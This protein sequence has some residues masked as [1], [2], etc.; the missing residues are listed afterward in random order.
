VPV[1]GLTLAERLILKAQRGLHCFPG[2]LA[3]KARD[4]LARQAEQVLN[5][6][7]LRAR[8]SL[9]P[10]SVYRRS[11]TP[12]R[13]PFLRFT[14]FIQL[15]GQ[16]LQVA[17]GKVVLKL[18][19]DGSSIDGA[20]V[21]LDEAILVTIT[22]EEAWLAGLDVYQSNGGMPH[23]DSED[24]SLV[25]S[26]LVQLID[27]ENPRDLNG[28][29]TLEEFERKRYAYRYEVTVR[30][31]LAPDLEAVT[32]LIDG[33]TGA[34]VR[35]LAG[36]TPFSA[37]PASFAKRVSLSTPFTLPQWILDGFCLR[38]DGEGV[39]QVGQLRRLSTSQRARVGT[40]GFSN[41]LY[42][43]NEASDRG[44]RDGEVVTFA[45]TDGPNLSPVEATGRTRVYDNND[46]VEAH[47][48]G[49]RIVRWARDLQVRSRITGRVPRFLSFVDYAAATPQDY[50]S[51]TPNDDPRSEFYG[52][53][54]IRFAVPTTGTGGGRVAFTADPFVAAHEFGHAM[55]YDATKYTGAPTTTSQITEGLADCIGMAFLG[56]E[57]T[58]ANVGRFSLELPEQY[59]LAV[60]SSV[61][62]PTRPGAGMFTATT[63]IR[64]GFLN[65][66]NPSASFA[67]PTSRFILWAGRAASGSAAERYDARFLLAG[68]C[69][70]I[71]NGG[72]HPVLANQQ[73]LYF[74][75]GNPVSGQGWD[76]MGQLVFDVLQ[77]GMVSSS[78]D[79]RTIRTAFE[80][81]A[82]RGRAVEERAVRRAFTFWG[83]G[84]DKELEPNSEVFDLRPSARES[85]LL[86]VGP[87]TG[88]PLTGAVG[89]PCSGFDSD[90]ADIFTVNEKVVRGDIIETRLEF[91]GERPP[92]GT[93]EARF[94]VREPCT[95]GITFSDY[96]CAADYQFHPAPSAEFD[97]YGQ[98]LYPTP[99]DPQ[100]GSFARVVVRDPPANPLGPGG[101]TDR[102]Q[103]LFVAVKISRGRIDQDVTKRYPYTLTV[104][105]THA[106]PPTAY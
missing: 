97:T 22:R 86:S 35:T 54:S 102:P 99:G 10:T 32:Y 43:C 20:Y 72:R 73:M 92:Q 60:G 14:Q 76:R 90:Q 2:T 15:D 49:E 33:E 16:E 58:N 64:N 79:I 51:W 9:P 55:V 4:K 83:F 78:T 71:A 89:C 27:I 63:D 44:V 69:A 19:P 105:V 61:D 91:T 96:S 53:G 42:S 93:L 67:E 88:T 37:Q 13:S 57:R 38:D 36:G 6:T 84:R 11:P 7:D 87:T 25:S 48:W 104:R 12:S 41:Q 80:E 21:A 31:A 98:T 39:G 18:A 94:Y 40:T 26:L 45:G 30:D 3:A 56:R 74:P 24:V 77:D 5:G 34:P 82:R 8:F 106:T 100:P 59:N 62:I 70:L 23:V 47:Y 28:N 75:D 68:P 85:N 50:A 66:S 52:D 65:L 29:D 17:G 101:G 46:A 81:S 103:P 1:P 95:P